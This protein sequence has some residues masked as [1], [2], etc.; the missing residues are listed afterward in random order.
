[1]ATLGGDLFAMQNHGARRDRSASLDRHALGHLDC[2]AARFDDAPDDRVRGRT[3]SRTNL[4]GRGEG[5]SPSRAAPWTT[6]SLCDI[7]GRR[8]SAANRAPPHGGD[9]NAQLTLHRDPGSPDP[10]PRAASGRLSEGPG[11]HGRL[12]ACADRVRAHPAGASGPDSAQSGPLDSSASHPGARTGTGDERV[13][14]GCPYRVSLPRRSI[15]ET[16]ISLVEESRG[17]FSGEGG[18]A[19]RP[20][21]LSSAMARLVIALVGQRPSPCRS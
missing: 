19:T 17:V 7:V 4:S 8:E 6:I 18:I 1:M 9:T 13:R 2:G 10:D 3:R 11:P 5:R 14:P 21:G 20:S 15:W 16:S 12:G